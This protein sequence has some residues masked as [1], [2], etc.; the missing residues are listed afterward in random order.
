VSEEAREPDLR[1]GAGRILRHVYTFRA[2]DQGVHPATRLAGFTDAIL[3]IAATLL[4][5]N[6]TVTSDRPGN[7]LAHQ[8]STQRAAL[9]SVLLGFIWI[10]GQ[11]VLS[12]RTLRQLRGIDHYMTLLVIASTLSITLIPFATL[13]LAHGYGHA[14]FWVGVEAV[15]LVVL[16]GTVLSAL[17]TDYAHRHGLLAVPAAPVQ[18]RAALTIWYAVTSLVVL[19]V[20]LAPWV[21]WLAF[22]IVVFTRLSALAPLASDRM[23]A[24]HASSD[25]ALPPER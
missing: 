20:L 17:G 6:L 3:A 1:P 2:A 8:I 24:D 21:P 11:W 13:L 7:G 15:C 12:H 18:R 16:I 4:V 22:A 14:D 19:A 10:A 5:L 9:V 23:T 25:A